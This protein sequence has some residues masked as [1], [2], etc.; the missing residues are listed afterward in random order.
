[1]IAQDTLGGNKQNKTKTHT[2]KL[3]ILLQCECA[4]L[5]T[6]GHYSVNLFLLVR[7]PRLHLH[8]EHTFE[9][10][11]KQNALTFL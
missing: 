5:L 11:E 8:H 7:P 10:Q 1:M 9:A 2:Q 6:A 4:L 3:L